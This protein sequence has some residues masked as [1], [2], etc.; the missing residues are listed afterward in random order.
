[1]KV[2]VCDDERLFRNELAGLLKSY[3]IERKTDV[4]VDFFQNGNE[5][6]SAKYVYDVIFMDYQLGGIDGIETCRRLREKNSDSVIIFISA[7]PGA[8]LDSFEVNTFRFLSKPLNKD[9]LFKALDDYM[10]SIDYDNLLILNTHDGK[11]NIKTSEIIYLEAAGKHTLVRT[12]S[13]TYEIHNN[14][15]S[16]EEMLPQDKF[17][18]CHKAFVVG[19]AHIRN[20][21]NEEILL[22][23]GEKAYIGKHYLRRFK[24]EF[25]NYIIRYNKGGR[26]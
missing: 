8:A 16:V 21:T 20:H 22:D 24:E 3:R 4:F 26:Q 17:L 11:W 2:A 12:T 9:K 25:Q 14:L 19:F 6:L 18:R 7:Y 15:K 13:R 5:L 23:N 10:Y 1:M